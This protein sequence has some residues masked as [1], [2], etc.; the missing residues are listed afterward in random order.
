LTPGSGLASYEPYR[1]VCHQQWRTLDINNNKNQINNQLF[2][3]NKKI[4]GLFKENHILFQT[5]HS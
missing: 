1:V 2:D 3:V 5:K 4:V